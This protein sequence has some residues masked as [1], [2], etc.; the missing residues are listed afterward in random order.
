MAFILLIWSFVNRAID[1]DVR[2]L[3]ERRERLIVA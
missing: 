3:V 1:M 2:Q